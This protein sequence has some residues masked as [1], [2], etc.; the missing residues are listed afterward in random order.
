M[1]EGGS[2]VIDTLTQ[3]EFHRVFQKPGE[4]TLKGTRVSG[5]YYQ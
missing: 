4:I 3:E 2:K 1:K 5:V